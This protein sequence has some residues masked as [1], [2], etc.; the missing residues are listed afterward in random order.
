MA[1]QSSTGW[2]TACVTH[3][4]HKSDPW[5]EEAESLAWV[6]GSHPSSTPTCLSWSCVCLAGMW[7]MLRRGLVWGDLSSQRT[8]SRAVTC[9]WAKTS[10][11]EVRSWVLRMPWWSSG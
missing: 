2:L 3:T 1:R 10:M 9:S 6:E 4:H 11:R 7:L 8:S 5:E